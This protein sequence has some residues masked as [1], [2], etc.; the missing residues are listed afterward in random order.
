M[1]HIVPK[2]YL[3]KNGFPKQGDYNQIANF[4]LTET[5]I[6]IAIKDHPPQEYM[7]WVATQIATGKLQIGEITSQGDL[8]ENLAENAIPEF[9]GDVTAHNYQEFLE[10]RRKLMAGMIREYYEAL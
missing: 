1:H 3:I 6:N 9:I 4:A 2:N 10:E 7:K 5:P 8:E